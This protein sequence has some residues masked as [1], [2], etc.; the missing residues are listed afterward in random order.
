[1]DD[2]TPPVT[3]MYF[4]SL[5]HTTLPKNRTTQRQALLTKRNR[6]KEYRRSAA[7]SPP[8]GGRWIPQM[9]ASTSRNTILPPGAREWNS[10]GAFSGWPNGA[11]V[12]TL[13]A[14]VHAQIQR[15]PL[16]DPRGRPVGNGRHGP[17]ACPGRGGPPLGRGCEDRHR[18]NGDAGVLGP[19]R[20]V[21]EG[22]LREVA[23]L[24]GDRLRDARRLLP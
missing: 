22:R 14:H 23:S 12:A 11:G 17:G 3:K 5:I 21:G 6:T 4:V 20:R 10:A 2:T 15:P 13:C 24:S 9:H 19:L 7:P 16:R 8:P 1:M 18:G